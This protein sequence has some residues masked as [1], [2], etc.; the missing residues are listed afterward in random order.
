MLDTAGE[1]LQHWSIVFEVTTDFAFPVQQISNF[2]WSNSNKVSNSTF[3][4]IQCNYVKRKNGIKS[5]APPQ[6]KRKQCKTFPRHLTEFEFSNGSFRSET[7]F[8][9]L[10][11]LCVNPF[12]IAEAKN[13]DRPV[14]HL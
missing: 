10:A 7:G 12:R 4:P 13:Q 5:I 6:Q 3:K 9:L 2:C 11:T 1:Q 8:G 14:R